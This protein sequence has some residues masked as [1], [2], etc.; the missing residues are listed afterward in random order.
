MAGISEFIDALIKDGSAFAKDELKALLKEARDDNRLF[1]RHMGELTEEFIKLRALNQI[2]NSEFE[3]LMK[4]VVDLNNMQ[5]QK[6]SA[7]AKARAQRIAT[8]LTDLVLKS[9]LALI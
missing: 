7:E 4:D 5:Y 3:E 9:L 1:I 2:N 8:G 6:L